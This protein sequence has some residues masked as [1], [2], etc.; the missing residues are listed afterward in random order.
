MPISNHCVI[1][2]DG[3]FFR[4]SENSDGC[5]FFT[6]DSATLTGCVDWAMGF[7]LNHRAQVVSREDHVGQKK[8]E[9]T[10]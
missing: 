8:E 7:C 10:G 9:D 6:L 3:K 2:P 5:Y 4:C 1:C